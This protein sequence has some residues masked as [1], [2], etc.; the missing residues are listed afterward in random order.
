MDQLFLNNLATSLDLR[1]DVLSN[2]INGCQV[3][4][5]FTNKGPYAITSDRWTIYF[6]SLRKINNSFNPKN[7][8]TV[9]HINGYLHKLRP[10]RHFQT[11][12]PGKHFKFDLNTQNAIISKTDVMP[13]W[14][15]AARG[16]EPRIIQST[17][18]E[19]LTF[20][21]P[22][23][24]PSK[25][26]RTAQDM[27]NPFTPEKRFNMNNIEDLNR[28]TN[29]ITPTPLVLNFES[30]SQKVN[31]RCGNWDVIAR[32][33]LANEGRYLAGSLISIYPLNWPVAKLAKF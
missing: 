13:N 16:L 29:L 20:V 23:D 18:G 28:A 32:R 22:F 33:S 17:A 27:Y 19:S 9:S 14:Y 25:W 5:T 15:V 1:F 24:T 12:L 30:A 21:G 7:K 11:L 6:S 26:K 8:M 4:L 10:T 2:L 3:R 31:L